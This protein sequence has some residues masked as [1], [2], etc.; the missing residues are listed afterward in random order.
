MRQMRIVIVGAVGALLA[1]AF[2]LA[3]KGQR[4]SSPLPVEDALKVRS[5]GRFVP[6]PDGRWF[7][8]TV[9]DN[10][11]RKSFSLES[12]TISGVPPFGVGAD[13]FVLNVA[14]GASKNLTE[15]T[16]D[17]WLPAWSPDGRKLAF[18]SDRG[19][20]HARLWIWDPVKDELRKASDARIQAEDV[21][22]T[23]DS[24]KILITAVPER[25]LTSGQVRE[26]SASVNQQ[27]LL[28]GKAPD[29]TVI[30]YTSGVESLHERN[31][32][33]SDPWDLDIF[34]RDLILVNV[35]DGSSSPIVQGRRIAQYRISP[36]GSRVAYTI[37]RRFE[38]AGSQQTLFDLVTVEVDTREVSV[39]KS[40]IRFDDDGTAFSWSPDGK[41]LAFRTGGMEERISDCYI[42]RANGG[43]SR[44][45]STFPA[46]EKRPAN[47]AGVPLWDAKGTNVYFLRNGVLWRSSVEGS[48][49]ERVAE[50]AERKIVRLIHW[51]GNL[52]WISPHDQQ[53]IV[54]T[55]DDLGKQ[56]G[57][58]RVDL[59]RGTSFKVMEKGQCYTCAHVAEWQF[60][61]VTNDGR[62]IAF[63][64]E[65]AQHSP[66]LWITG[67][68]FREIRR[69][70]HLNPQFDEVSMGSARLIEW[71]A[72]D[73]QSLKGALLLP[74]NYEEGKSYPLLVWVYGGRFLS[75]Q[76]DHFGLGYEG[77]FN[78]Q[79]FATRGY[80]VLMPDAPQQ[81]G[82]P[83][84]D[85]AKTVLPGVDRVMEMG[86]ADPGR[87]GVM[88]H[89]Y[90]SYCTLSLIVQ[91]NRFKAAMAADGLGDLI[92]GYGQM[93]RDGTS[94]GVAI[95]E[96]GQELMGGPPWQFR[97]RYI[98]NS[99]IFYLDKVETP[100]LIVHGEED[101]AVASFLGDELFVGLRRLG[102]EVQYAKYQGEGHTPQDW[103]YANQ[104]DF[105]NR[106]I[107]W[108]DDH[109]K[110]PK[111]EKQ[112]K[113]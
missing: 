101:R 81:M 98:E 19:S 34:L 8:Y 74:S 28:T 109:L 14:S 89:S 65:D 46:S 80:A 1:L 96:E 23:P 21:V 38:K 68:S 62:S 64:S 30:L 32:P 22:W 95:A 110:K 5:F 92:S 86:I 40:D 108:F 113:N 35:A 107:A 102:K 58:Y 27:G 2:S 25:L 57:F 42:I 18:L 90:G 100:L 45:V 53:T 54:V 50:I 56:D 91:T 79:L 39:L 9:Q 88:G 106:M 84:A 72:E 26:K 13:I 66:E 49:A 48:T 104:L 94:Y 85:L 11:R 83:M 61:E 63:Y 82:T 67:P 20:D 43:G 59:E 15:S 103:S 52:L 44:N 4:A 105:C 70:T 75:N 71:R 12:Y 51:S 69:L 87:L 29:S 73:G 41:S 47:R 97:D 31:G 78:M 99:P 6:A 37:P 7:A 33:R 17:N 77:P 10:Q 24:R 16:G 112:E 60:A 76:I 3:I 36:D 93:N 111:A 55:H